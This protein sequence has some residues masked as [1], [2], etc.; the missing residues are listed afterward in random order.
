MKPGSRMRATWRPSL[1]AGSWLP[2]D[3]YP[4]IDH[5]HNKGILFGLWVEIESI[6]AN[7]ALR[8]EHPDW[9][10]TRNGE[11]VAHGRHLDVA[12]PAVAEWMESQLVDII[13]RY[14]LDL[15]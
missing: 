7:S 15:Y 3:L 2:N 1:A 4:I 8:R 9:V 5:A 11:P 14:K 13:D 6:G 12:N 10:L